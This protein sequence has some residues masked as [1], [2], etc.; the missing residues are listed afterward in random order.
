MAKTKRQNSKNSRHAPFSKNAPKVL[1]YDA[2]ATLNRDFEQVVADLERLEGLR[3]FPRRWQRQFLKVWRAT[4]EESRAWV[5]FEVIE[6]L[7]QKE[8]REW[9][10]FAHIRQRS[11]KPSEPPADMAAHAK[12]GGRKSQR[13]K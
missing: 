8:E 11:E 4:L 2:L 13:R 9:V 7:H 5:N 10:R 3:I 12:S 6:V 1:V